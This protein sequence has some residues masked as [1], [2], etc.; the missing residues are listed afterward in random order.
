VAHNP[1]LEYMYEALEQKH[2][3]VPM[4][5]LAPED[6]KKE[7][8]TTATLPAPG[9]AANLALAMAMAMALT[10]A[11]R[12]AKQLGNSSC[13]VLKAATATSS[14]TTDTTPSPLRR[15]TGS[16][17]GGAMPAQAGLPSKAAE[18]NVDKATSWLTSPPARELSLSLLVGGSGGRRLALAGRRQ[19][20]R[21]VMVLELA[22]WGD[23]LLGGRCQP[24][25]LECPFGHST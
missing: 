3:G 9:G 20:T 17:K 23:R 10:A 14:S 25:Q 8:E 11:A 2:K 5:A 21:C 4:L 15:Y 24:R 16:D 19:A 6:V 12:Q 22:G 13:L 7:P 18:T 1:L